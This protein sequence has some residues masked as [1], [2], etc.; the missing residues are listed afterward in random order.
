MNQRYKIIL[1]GK[2]IYKEIELAQNAQQVKVGTELGCDV[3]LHRGLFFEPFEL[4]FVNAEGNWNVYCSDNLYLTAGD[5]RKFES[6]KLSH[7]DVLE[8]KLILSILVYTF[9]TRDYT[10]AWCDSLCERESQK[11]KGVWGKG[12]V[13]FSSRP[14]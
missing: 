7:G 6:K 12:K 11:E 10:I 14:P 4:V 2:H 3:R 13:A 8:V 5:I 9:Y 1:S